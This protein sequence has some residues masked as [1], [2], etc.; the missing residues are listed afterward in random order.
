MTRRSESGASWNR[1]TPQFIEVLYILG[2]PRQRLSLLIACPSKEDYF[3]ALSNARANVS[4]S[5]VPAAKSSTAFSR[6]PAAS[7]GK[8]TGW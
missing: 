3:S 1:L 8:N 2:E 7:L 4:G 6:L 5:I